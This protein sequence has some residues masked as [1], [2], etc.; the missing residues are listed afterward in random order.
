M[1]PIVHRHAAH[2]ILPPHILRNIAMNATSKELRD[3]AIQALD[4]DHTLRTSRVSFTLAGGL[5]L[6]HQAQA[7][8]AP[9]KKRTIY[10]DKQT[11]NLPGTLVRAE[12][13]APVSSASRWKAT[14]PKP[15]APSRR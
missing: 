9:Q 6:H 13:Q 5:Q 2:C 3:F 15:C 12:G 4:L 8:A 1:R 11:Q 10:D 7:A 14:T